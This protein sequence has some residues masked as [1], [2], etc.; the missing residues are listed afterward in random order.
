MSVSGRC[1]SWAVLTL[2]LSDRTMTGLTL[3][4]SPWSL[5]ALSADGCESTDVWQEQEKAR[6]LL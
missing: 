1:C 5:R 4:C 2:R 6:A 3:C